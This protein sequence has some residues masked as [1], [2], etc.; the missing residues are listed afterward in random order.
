M[1]DEIK[2]IINNFNVVSFDI[3]DTLLVSSFIDNNDKFDYIAVLKNIPDFKNLRIKAENKARCLKQIKSD[4]VIEDVA[5]TEIYNYLSEEYLDL[6]DLEKQL[7][8][9]SLRKNKELYEIYNYALSQN[10]KIIIVSDSYYDSKFLKYL[11]NKNGYNGFER[12]FSSSDIGKM[13]STGNLF[14][15][16][17]SSLSIEPG[18]IVHIGDNKKADFEKALENGLRAFHYSSAKDKLKK[19]NP[20][21]LN[22]Y[23]KYRAYFSPI[24]GLQLLKGENIT[25]YWERLGYNIG[26]VLCYF[27]LQSV[28]QTVK[29]NKISDVFFIAR[30]C[31]IFSKISENFFGE[32]CPRFHYIYVNRNINKLYNNT[33][34]ESNEF[35]RY[36]KS[37]N[38]KGERILVVD[39]CAK[40]FSA[41]TLIEKY[42]KDMHIE[43]LYLSVKHNNSINYSTLTSYNWENFNLFNWNFIEFLLSSCER[44]IVD[45]KDLKPV[46]QSDIDKNEE[47]RLKLYKHLYVGNMKFMTDFHE[48]FSEASLCVPMDIIFEFIGVFW[49]NLTETDKVNLSKIRHPVDSHQNTYVSILNPKKDFAKLLR[50]RIKDNRSLLCNIKH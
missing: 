18:K 9:M 23:N 21:I 32:N 20:A 19:F 43:G 31:Y 33:V 13:K 8:L 41:Q 40:T 42:L 7:D 30:D 49:D 26:G 44:P 27:F 39:T 15:Y 50:A 25:N 10:K 14:K 16:V 37:I 24:I 4:K 3:F 29:K 5:L 11:L 1:N 2:K 36:I 45:I 48:M 34:L 46:Y 17:V 28:I 22:F 35:S 12:I 47:L 38:L 6:I